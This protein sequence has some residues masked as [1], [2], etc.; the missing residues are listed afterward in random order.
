MLIKNKGMLHGTM[1][2]KFPVFPSINRAKQTMKIPTL[3]VD[4]IKENRCSNF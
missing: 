2:I 1:E 3:F 4:T